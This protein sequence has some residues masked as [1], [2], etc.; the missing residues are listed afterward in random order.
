MTDFFNPNLLV[1]GYEINLRHFLPNQKVISQ[2]NHTAM[3]NS[4]WTTNSQ[5][6]SYFQN[7]KVCRKMFD[8]CVHA[9]LRS[10]IDKIELQTTL[11]TMQKLKHEDKF[12]NREAQN[13][14][15]LIQSVSCVGISRYMYLS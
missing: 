3:N 15:V 5:S 7:L 6:F 12:L 1:S 14:I 11:H 2:M 4:I 10:F 8:F 9:L 13:E